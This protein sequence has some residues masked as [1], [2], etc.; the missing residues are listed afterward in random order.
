MVRGGADMKE[1]KRLNVHIGLGIKSAREAAGL[2]QEKFAE[3]IGMG[4]KNVSAIERGLAGISVP[5]LR[6]ICETLSI[7]SDSLIM[8]NS[9]N[10]NVGKVD[11]LAERLKNLPPQKL[12]LALDICNKLFEIFV[13]KEKSQE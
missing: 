12:E 1:K 10:V 7:S 5:A 6:R 3:L 4:T 8:D 9:I 2:S 13:L 11:I